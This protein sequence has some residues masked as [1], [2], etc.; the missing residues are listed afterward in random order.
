MSKDSGRTW[1]RRLTRSLK[2]AYE[3]RPNSE[4]NEGPGVK[5]GREPRLGWRGGWS[6]GGGSGV[7]GWG[8]GGGGG[9]RPE[10]RH[11]RVGGGCCRGSAVR[12][13]SGQAPWRMRTSLGGRFERSEKTAAGRPKGVRAEAII[14]V[15]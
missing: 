1:P 7:G 4:E 11:Y 13:R 5:L 2:E 10:P 15:Q 6:G 14:N 3:G 8:G 12:L 9:G